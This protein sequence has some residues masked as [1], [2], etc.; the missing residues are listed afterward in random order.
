[1]LRSGRRSLIISPFAIQQGY[2]LKYLVPIYILPSQCR[3]VILLDIRSAQ[4]GVDAGGTN[5]YPLASHPDMAF[6][7]VGSTNHH[8][9][10]I[11]FSDYVQISQWWFIQQ[12]MP[13][14][15]L[16][17]F[18]MCSE[19]SRT[20]LNALLNDQLSF[21][22]GG[23]V[24]MTVRLDKSMSVKVYIGLRGSGRR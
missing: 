5:V 1:M 23:V 18:H 9:V 2:D 12:A 21:V 6:R 14:S 11:K 8:Q 16:Y 3:E 10:G 20:Q 7:L 13:P 19:G 4:E 15:P 22:E 17:L 24:T